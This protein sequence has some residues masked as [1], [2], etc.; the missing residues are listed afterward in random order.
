MPYLGNTPSTSFATVVKDS[1]NGGS[2]AYT[3]SKVAT[4]NSVSVFVENV[5]QE[6]T[7]AYAV[8]G[9][10]LTFTATTPS[11]TGN[12]YVL[13][14]NPTTTTTHPAAQ[15]LT[16]TTG[17]FTSTVDVNGNELILDA[18]A[19]TSITADTDDTIDIKIGGS[20]IFQMTASKLDLNGKELILDADGDTSITSDTDDEIDFKTAGTDRFLIDS[21]GFLRQRF[22]SDNSTTAEGFFINNM[23][24][25]TGNN[26][27]LIFSN[28]SGGRKK[29]A[30][31]HIDT[32]TYGAGD[33]VFAIDGADSGALHLTNDEKMRIDSS[34]NV[35]MPSQPAFHATSTGSGFGHDSIMVFNTA[36]VNTGSHYN[37][38]NGKFTAPVAGVYFFYHKNIGTSSST[39]IRVKV[40]YNDSIFT[41]YKTPSTRQDTST[42]NDYAEGVINF[43]VSL[44]ANDTIKLGTFADDSSSGIYND[45]SGGQGFNYFGGYLIG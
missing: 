9:T 18:D 27:S 26:A 3:L 13:H 45:N 1:F 43:V 12:I 16:A 41:A 44:S 36:H 17:T 34:G 6:P 10:T 33:L 38:S 29:A 37:T 5:R 40:Y 23:Q 35:T 7:T 8:S 25:S 28:D 31:A 24:N 4:T 42:G 21:S 19:D 30:I 22:T 15:A 11:G 14:M 32:G 39:V 2:T 20:D